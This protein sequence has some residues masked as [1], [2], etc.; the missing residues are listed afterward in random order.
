MI[1]DDIHWSRGMQAAWEQ[2]KQHPRVRLSLD[3]FYVGLVFFDPA[4]KEKQDF[5]LFL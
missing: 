4:F 5:S 3:L 1:F 2:I